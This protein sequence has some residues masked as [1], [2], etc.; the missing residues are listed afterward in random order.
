VPACLD[1]PLKPVEYES[2]ADIET[3]VSL[4]LN[5]DVDIMFVIDNSGSM[6]E[7]Q[8]TLAANFERFIDRLEAPDV[9]ANYRLGITT[10]DNGNP[11]CDGTTPE[12]GALR[13]STCRSRQ[14]EFVFNGAE[15]IDATQEACL[16]ICEHDSIDVQPTSTANDPTPKP[17]PWLESIE[18]KSNLP[19]ADGD[20]VTDMSTADAFRCFGPQ[21]ING[22]GFEQHLESMYKGLKRTEDTNEASYDFLRDSAILSVVF[23]TDE[24][25]CSHNNEWSEIFLPT[26]NGGNEVF[27]SDPDGQ[28][29]PTS[30]VCWNAGVECTGGEG[31]GPYEECHA[32]DKDVDGNV[33]SASA[34]ADDAVLHPLARYV[35]LLQAYEDDK[36]REVL[37]ASI[38]GVPEG[39]EMGSVDMRYQDSLDTQDQL[40]FGIGPACETSNGKA[41]PSVRVRELA[42]A[43]NVPLE[44]NPNSRN[45]YSACAENYDTALDGIVDAIIAQLKPPCMTA[46]VADSQPLSPDTLE[47]YCALE[48]VTPDGVGTS[49]RECEAGGVLPDGADVCFVMLTG[50]A[51]S[52]ECAAEGWNLEFDLVR[53]D[54]VAPPAGTNVNATC[55]LSQQKSIDC[56][57]LP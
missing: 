21:G 53:R 45:L 18:G 12:G 46:C 4:V 17:R 51:M 1:H 40:D 42:E 38:D 52:M 16:D 32:V 11:W 29:S 37:I 57:N 39:Y 23:I 3:T 20:G 34:A 9:D 8:A 31:G 27:W 13:L 26:E 43:F 33:V 47:P 30:A 35:D 2:S 10:T 14:Q 36:E 44:M 15:S 48:E 50:G 41:V 56:P 7:E 22:C 55:Q 54:G 6:A 49:V 5:K 19:D 25:D 28:S 24:A